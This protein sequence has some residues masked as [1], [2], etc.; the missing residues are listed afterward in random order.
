MK[1]YFLKHKG[2]CIL[3]LIF[4]LLNASVAVIMAQ[5]LSE[6]T[7]F[8]LHGGEELGSLLLKI[9]AFCAYILFIYVAYDYIKAVYVCAIM[10]DLE[11]D[12]YESIIRQEIYHFHLIE[13]SEYSSFFLNDLKLIE[14]NY[15]KQ[16]PNLLSGT[17]QMIVNGVYVGLLNGWILLLFVIS[18]LIMLWIPKLTSPRIQKKMDLFSGMARH[19]TSFLKETF[20]GFDTIASNHARLSYIRKTRSEFLLYQKSKQESELAM[21][22]SNSA[23]SIFG[24]TFQMLLILSMGFFIWRGML[25]ADYMFSIVSISGTFLGNVSTAIHAYTSIQS[26]RPIRKKWKEIRAFSSIIEER[27][28]P[29]DRLVLDHVTYAINERKI[30][31]DLTYTFEK[32]KRYLIIGESGSGKTTLFHLL[33]GRL[34]PQSGTITQDEN[35]IMDRSFITTISQ[36]PVSFKDTVLGNITLNRTDKESGVSELLEKV[37]L[38]QK[39]LSQIVG[40]DHSTLSGGELQR[41]SI[42]RSLLDPRSFLLCDEST[43]NLDPQTSRLIE[44][45]VTGLHGVG[46]LWI[47]HHITPHTIKLF[48][49]I[50]QLDHGTLRDVTGQ[51]KQPEERE[52]QTNQKTRTE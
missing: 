4:M 32:G 27:E 21:E 15:L 42:A 52:G 44:E 48:D 24:L 46:I 30:I 11:Q 31:D 45:V 13:P 18:S 10:T 34:R 47:T 9:A 49:V 28:Y 3:Y 2:I 50:L 36:T 38:D 29:Q 43:A 26:S 5:L 8:A 12:A 35:G 17:I 33:S 25:S 19:F 23:S 41:I 6:I 20:S 16:I 1:K 51:Y 14:E 7:D 37:C 39:L 22:L 40:E